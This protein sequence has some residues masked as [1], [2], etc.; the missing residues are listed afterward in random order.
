[1]PASDRNPQ[2]LY[3]KVLSA[4]VVDEK[5]DGTI[6]LYIGKIA[7]CTLPLPR[8]ALAELSVD[9]SSVPLVEPFFADIAT[10]DRHLVHEVTSP[11]RSLALPL[12]SISSV[13][14]TRPPAFGKHGRLR[15]TCMVRSLTWGGGFSKRSRVCATLAVKSAAQTA[16]W[17]LPITYV[18]AL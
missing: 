13:D 7:S 3:D 4:H 17:P 5:L 6:L 11:V 9:V 15:L 2:T 10:T 18:V 14:I 12:Y 1:M 16:L 8:S